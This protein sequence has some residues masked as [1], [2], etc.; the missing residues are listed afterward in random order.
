MTTRRTF[1]IAIAAFLVA[2]VPLL[3]GIGAALPVTE[4]MG[5]YRVEDIHDAVAFVRDLQV[6]IPPQLA[7]VE[8]AEYRLTGDISIATGFLYH[9]YIVVSYACVLALAYPSR[10][11]LTISGGLALVFVFSTRLIHPGNPQIYDVAAPCFCLLFVLLLRIGTA[12][13]TGGIGALVAAGFFLSMFELSRPFVIYLLP[14]VIAAACIRIANRRR[15]LCFVI[16]VLVLSGVW[17]VHLL[18]AHS[19]LIAS[20]HYGF[21][22]W[23][24]WRAKVGDRAEMVLE[25]NAPLAP[26]RMPNLNTPEHRENSERLRRQVRDHIAAHPI[27]SVR[28]VAL[29]IYR[30]TSGKTWLVHHEPSSWV[31][32]L[33]K[34]AI[35]VTSYLILLGFALLLGKI[36]SC[37]VRRHEALAALIGDTNSIVLFVGGASIILIAIGDVLEEARFALFFLP[38]LATVP[39]IH[40]LVDVDWSLLAAR[41]RAQR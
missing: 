10:A 26:G 12:R 31:L 9:A 8:I 18:T 37:A 35:R 3:W 6:P 5:I 1:A 32:R 20:N 25:P 11:R 16:P 23:R 15:A 41:L 36:A 21:N 27:D 33:Y 17:H 30:L 4:W 22:L 14:F 29:R 38:L 39:P 40:R 19:Q 34:P 2:C 24:C 13:Q 7:L 28:Y